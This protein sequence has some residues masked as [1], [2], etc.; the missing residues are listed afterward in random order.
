M[1]SLK[2]TRYATRCIIPG[3]YHVCV[4]STRLH[5]RTRKYPTP[6]FRAPPRCVGD[7]FCSSK[8]S[9]PCVYPVSS[10]SR[11]TTKKKANA[12]VSKP[13][14]PFFF[15]FSS[16]FCCPSL[17]LS[18]FFS[19]EFVFRKDWPV[20]VGVLRA[21]AI[22]T[23]PAF[24]LLPPHRGSSRSPCPSQRGEAMTETQRYADGVLH[25]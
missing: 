22:H 3:R 2:H 13:R 5:A 24:T 18:F 14:K 11:C 1:H 21:S 10:L 23:T 17:V 4:Y 16:F 15:S 7:L 20:G 6:A 19:L 9:Y 12:R 25:G 8:E